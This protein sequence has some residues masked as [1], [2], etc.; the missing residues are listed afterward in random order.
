VTTDAP[1][2]LSLSVVERGV[3]IATVVGRHTVTVTRS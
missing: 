3:E 1:G 2:A